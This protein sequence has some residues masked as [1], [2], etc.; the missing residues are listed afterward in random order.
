MA[1]ILLPEASVRRKVWT[2]WLKRLG[3]LFLYLIDLF[4]TIIFCSQLIRWRSSAIA[5]N[6][7]IQG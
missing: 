7:S 6:N 4:R 5:F 2:A 3:T 1:N